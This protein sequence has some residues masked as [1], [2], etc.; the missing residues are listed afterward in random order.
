MERGRLA[1]FHF[2]LNAGETPA[3]H[4]KQRG[5]NGMFMAKS[6]L[7]NVARLIRVKLSGMTSGVLV[8]SAIL[9]ATFLLV[10]LIINI[11]KLFPANDFLKHH[12]FLDYSPWFMAGLAVVIA[13]TNSYYRQINRNFEVYPQT[14][15]SRF[16][17]TQALSYIWIILAAVL[18]VVLYAIQYGAVAGIASFL[19]NI[20]LINKFEAEFVLVG[21]AVMIVYLSVI[22]GFASLIAALIRKFGVPTVIFIAAI[23]GFTLG[24]DDIAESVVG[25]LTF[26]PSLILFFIKGVATCLV[27]FVIT[28][29][30]DKR[31]VYVGESAMISEGFASGLTAAFIIFVLLVNVQWNEYQYEHGKKYVY[32]V[33]R[34]K[35]SA[36]IELWEW[37][38]AESHG[39]IVLDASALPKG[40]KINI[41]DGVKIVDPQQY[42]K[43]KNFYYFGDHFTSPH[44][45]LKYD[46]RELSDF[47]GEKLVI[48]YKLKHLVINWRD[49]RSP[50][51]QKVSARLEGTTLYIDYTYDKDYIYDKNVK[52][53]FIP[54][55]WFMRQ[56]DYYKSIINS[57]TLANNDFLRVSIKVL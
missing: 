28:F 24:R 16:L 57:Y 23:I 30:V 8:I 50:A 5:G 4:I 51:D 15:V 29:F 39:E 20:H 21:F 46:P 3:L 11:F 55:W 1:R 35:S 6:E 36:E 9:I 12:L 19:K 33:V 41:S 43:N 10:T 53:A 40:S 54:V 49:L 14:G 56:F 26:E 48:S 22:A 32:N 31:T 37:T 44:I 42:L 34:P 18:C 7:K 13:V 2:L 38:N 45:L 25:S 52:T 17:S 27:L 47:T